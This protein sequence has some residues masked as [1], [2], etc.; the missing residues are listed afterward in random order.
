MYVGEISDHTNVFEYFMT[1]PRVPSR[2]NPHVFVSDSQ[3]LNVINLVKNDEKLSSIRYIYSSKFTYFIYRFFMKFIVS[4]RLLNFI[5]F[6]LSIAKQDGNEVPVSLL[7]IT[8][9]DSE[10]G[11][12]QGLEALKYLVICYYYINC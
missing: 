7:L 12:K 4:I 6:I 1:L 3:P 2:R 8:N 5:I 10:Y 9:F 11:A